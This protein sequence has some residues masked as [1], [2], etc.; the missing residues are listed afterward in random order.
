MAAFTL[1]EVATGVAV[2]GILLLSFYTLVANGFNLVR[3][4]RE[5]LRA[6]QILINRIEGLRLYTWTQLVS[7][8]L[9]PTNFTEF[10]YPLGETNARGTVYWGTMTLS[11]PVLDPPASYATNRMRN[12]TLTLQWSTGGLQH[13]RS[14]STLVAEYGIQNYIYTH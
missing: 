5:N 6:S 12:V 13:T 9:A 7:N 10:Y 2:I 4:N 8:H 3:M 11:N 14:M 1:A